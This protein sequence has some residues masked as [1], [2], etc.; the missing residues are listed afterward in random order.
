MFYHFYLWPIKG[1]REE[2]QLSRWSGWRLRHRGHG[3][4][5]SVPFALPF[6]PY[7]W[8]LNRTRL[9]TFSVNRTC[10]V[11]LRPA[12]GRDSRSGTQTVLAG[13]WGRKPTCTKLDPDKEN[14]SVTQVH[15][16]ISFLAQHNTKKKRCQDPKRASMCMWRYN[17]SRANKQQARSRFVIPKILVEL[18]SIWLVLKVI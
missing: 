1:Q 2:M 14:D 11:L 7:C 8:S 16:K 5:R 10:A 4:R 15:S 6:S 12:G 13:H 18:I 3:E 9:D 17:Q